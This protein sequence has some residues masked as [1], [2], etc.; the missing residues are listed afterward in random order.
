MNIMKEKYLYQQAIS[1]E[2]L[3]FYSDIPLFFLIK[4]YELNDL[5]NTIKIKKVKKVKNNV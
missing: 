3:I 5:N 1:K 4:I 2:N